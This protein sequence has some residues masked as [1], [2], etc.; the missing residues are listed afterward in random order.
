MSDSGRGHETSPSRHGYGYPNC[1][2]QSDQGAFRL[3]DLPCPAS[4]KFPTA[5]LRYSPNTV[6]DGKLYYAARPEDWK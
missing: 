5:A 1:G 3:H 6:R 2:T 4:G